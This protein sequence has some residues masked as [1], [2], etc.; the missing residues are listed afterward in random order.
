MIRYESNTTFVIYTEHK[1]KLHFKTTSM[2]FLKYNS[3]NV[4]FVNR[5]TSVNRI[6]EKYSK[7][8]KRN[9]DFQSYLPMFDIFSY[10]PHNFIFKSKYQPKLKLFITHN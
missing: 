10:N 2:Q 7:N 4:D 8:E 9:F 1:F 3:R 5:L 6:S